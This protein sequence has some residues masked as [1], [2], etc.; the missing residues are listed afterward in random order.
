LEHKC[1]PNYSFPHSTQYSTRQTLQPVFIHCTHSDD[2]SRQNET[3]LKM[4]RSDPLRNKQT[5]SRADVFQ[6]T[7]S[8]TYFTSQE[9]KQL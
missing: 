1:I 8:S 6:A 7:R 2:V 4:A 3:P 9:L 5:P